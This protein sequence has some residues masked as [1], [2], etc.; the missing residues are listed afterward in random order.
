[1]DEVLTPDSSRFWPVEGLVE[2]ENPPSL[3]KQ[4]VRDWLEQVTIDGKPWNKKPPPPALPER[5]W[6]RRRRALSAR[7]RRCCADGVCEFNQREN[8]DESSERDCSC[9]GALSLSSLATGAWAKEDKAT[10]Q[11][12]VVKS[13]GR[14]AGTLLARPSRS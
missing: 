10:K 1:M 5:A 6:S 4:F 9:C 7:A 3:D 13:H 2:G 8:V 14:G 11:A 12:E